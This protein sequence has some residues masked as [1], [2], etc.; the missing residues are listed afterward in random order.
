MNATQIYFLVAGVVL[1]VIAWILLAFRKS[2]NINRF[3]P[4]ASLAYVFILSGLLFGENRVVGYGLMGV[5][6]ILAIVTI[7]QRSRLP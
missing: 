4:L 5:G 3:D 6:L 2:K 7:I 1:I